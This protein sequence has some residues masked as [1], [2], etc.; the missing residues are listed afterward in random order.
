MTNDAQ[1]VIICWTQANTQSIFLC[2]FDKRKFR[3]FFDLLKPKKKNENRLWISIQST[4]RLNKIPCVGHRVNKIPNVSASAVDER[5]RKGIWFSLSAAQ[6]LVW[7]RRY[8]RSAFFMSTP[9]EIDSFEMFTER[10]NKTHKYGKWHS[11][12]Y[13]NLQQRIINLYFWRKK[14]NRFVLIPRKLNTM[15]M[16]W[17]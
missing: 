17:S 8:T 5:S 16:V 13:M 12:I 11:T 6:G 15:A 7:R 2:Q 14:N 10:M 1:C 4:N 9:I 3:I